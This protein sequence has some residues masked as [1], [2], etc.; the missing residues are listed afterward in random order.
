MTPNLGIWLSLLCLSVIAIQLS[1]SFEI[2]ITPW[3]QTGPKWN[4][5]ILINQSCS[6]AEPIG[7]WCLAFALE[8]LF[9]SNHMLGNP[10]VQF[11][12]TGFLQFPQSTALKLNKMLHL[13]DNECL[14]SRLD[15]TKQKFWN[16]K[17]KFFSDFTF[18]YLP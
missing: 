6:L 3:G 13:S 18:L 15:Q 16:A 11:Q 14:R 2:W 12:S 10:D 9:H 4:T 7:P 8:Q 17:H 1:P 5:N